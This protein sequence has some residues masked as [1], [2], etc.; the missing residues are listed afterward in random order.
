L[1][2]VSGEDEIDGNQV[3]IDKDDEVVDVKMDEGGCGCCFVVEERGDEEGST[4]QRR[5][6]MCGPRGLL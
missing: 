3:A 2:R 5:V 1:Q 6:L 4:K